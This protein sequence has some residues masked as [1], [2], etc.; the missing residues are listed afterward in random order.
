[1][2]GRV[3]VDTDVISYIFRRD[4]RAEPFVALLSGTEIVIS[5]MT[6]AELDLWALTRNWSPAR[7]AR[8]NAYVD[9][10]TIAMP[11]RD[12]CRAWAAIRHA[13][14]LRGR[15]IETADAWIAATAIALAC[16][17][18][19]NNWSDYESVDGLTLLQ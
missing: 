12:L 6:L 18:A 19:T 2:P 7:T 1:M 14:R 8:L 10:F 3:V 4:T 13:A 11:T 16:P 5:F 15:Q 17:L 9:T